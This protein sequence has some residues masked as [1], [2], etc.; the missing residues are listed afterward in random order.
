[1]LIKLQATNEMRN[2]DFG[3]RIG[4]T[5]ARILKSAIR[6]PQSAII[7]ALFIFTAGVVSAQTPAPSPST[8]QQA[9]PA[10]TQTQQQQQPGQPPPSRI[11]LPPNSSSA[12]V[13]PDNEAQ[14]S[15]QPQTGLEQER[16]QTTPNTQGPRPPSPQVQPQSQQTAP[17]QQQPTQATPAGTQA[18]PG[19][20]P[21]ASPA[22]GVVPQSPGQNVG[23]S[24]G[25]APAELPQEPPPVAPNFRAPARPLPSAERVGVDVSDQMP[26]TLNDAIAL[27]LQNNND[28]DGSRINVQ[29]AEYELKAAR[30]VYDPIFSS[31]SYYESRVTPTSS[32][33]GGAQNGSVMQ[34]D[35]TGAAR[36]GGFSPFAGGAYQ[37]D[38]SST[39][40]TT[41]N[42][43][44]TLNPQFPT[45]FTLT[46]TQ[47]L[48]RGLRFDNNRRQIEIAKKNL[49]LTDAQ[50]RQRAI[51]VISQVE[52]A[53]WDLV[54]S[55]RN[56]QVQIDAV[57]QA[58]TQVES[59]QRLVEKGV[60]AP[61]DIIAANTQVTTFE[62]NVYTAQEA[63][64]R[65]E[66]TLKT[67]MLPARTDALWSR[68]LTPI[69][70]INL[71][72]PRV[73]LEQAVNAAL[74]SRPEL[75]QL[76]T[77]AEINQIDTRFFRDQ[78]K[79]QV[80]LVGTYTSVGLAGALTSAASGG[81][82]SSGSSSN[83]QF[84]ARVNELSTLAGLTPLETTTSG[85]TVTPNL[86]GGY[87]KSLS[88]LL[89]QDYPTYRVG[90]RVALPLRNRTA[91]ANLGRSLAQGS[92][93][94]NQR[95]Q[96]EQIIEADVRNTS[97]TLR[98]AEARLQ[99]AA[100]TRFSTEQQYESEQR[101]FRAGTSTV[102]LVLQRQNELLAARGRELQ[103]QTDLNKAIAEFERATGNTLAANNVAVRSDTPTRQLEIQRP[104]PEAG[105]SN[106]GGGSVF[107]ERGAA[108]A[109]AVEV[110]AND[111]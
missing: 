82:T 107:T 55:L 21:T 45:A 93:I 56:L 64:T 75:A 38:F 9:P 92:F 87:G 72:A 101:Q 99:A 11:Q 47:P 70:P 84:R 29:I 89:G 6:N 108:S 35:L 104:A 65:A 73:P 59:N 69:T 32:T 61:I 51:E 80:D 58:R 100:S 8:P 62:Q 91:E 22:N 42:Q 27:A 14:Q 7:T 49:S 10:G 60:L 30:G 103:A 53:Y 98:S 44:V 81:S 1:M 33:L 67:L 50:F 79:P 40:L 102:F 105:V 41:N 83:A 76:Q 106:S 74:K 3:M 110:K 63:V 46:Y 17:G 18:P 13:R 95:A 77:N 88:N 36:L 34:T 37:L 97:Q 78:T 68:P 26:L 25:I 28:I 52:Q 48:W 90:V 54:F 109:A 2:A 66:N 111:K 39:R 24:A 4:K 20:T 85:G 12:P 96:A 43:N 86:V 94:Q 31:E 19:T 15:T 23:V 71:E 16:Q 57:K 5:I